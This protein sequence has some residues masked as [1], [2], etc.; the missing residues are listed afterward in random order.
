MLQDVAVLKLQNKRDVVTEN[1]A[2]LLFT[3]NSA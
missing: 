3:Y 1:L 2:L